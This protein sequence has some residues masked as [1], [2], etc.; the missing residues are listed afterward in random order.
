MSQQY[1][2]LNLAIVLV[3]FW[4]LLLHFELHVFRES[5]SCHSP[6]THYAASRDFP[7]WIY[8]RCYVGNEPSMIHG[9]TSDD[10]S[11]H[12]RWSLNFF[13]CTCV[14]IYFAGQEFGL[15]APWVIFSTLCL[16]YVFYSEINLAGWRCAFLLSK[17]KIECE[18]LSHILHFTLM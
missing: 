11:L 12:L 10:A 18:L 4:C 6:C 14:D 3:C 8:I 9:V 13:L 2:Y 15:R 7:T 5:R 1:Y 16:K 17:E